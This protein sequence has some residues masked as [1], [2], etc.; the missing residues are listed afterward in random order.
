MKFEKVQ[1]GMVLYDVHS[2]Q[3]GNTTMRSM[4]CWAVR[5]ISIDVEKRQALASWNG[6]P[7]RLYFERD[8]K[9][10]RAVKPEMERSITG[11]YS[12]K[13]RAK[14]SATKRSAGK[15]GGK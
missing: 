9:R 8:L 2:Y 14:R 1:P 13:R 5:I 15:G 11:A 3:M 4:G 10:L 7:P 12:I 6:N